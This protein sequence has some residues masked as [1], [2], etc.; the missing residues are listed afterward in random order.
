MPSTTGVGLIKGFSDNVFGE[1]FIIYMTCCDV[2]LMPSSTI[3]DFWEPRNTLKNTEQIE[4]S[5]RW[6]RLSSFTK[7]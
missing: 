3:F 6:R 2:I 4:S 1:K 7:H 5:R